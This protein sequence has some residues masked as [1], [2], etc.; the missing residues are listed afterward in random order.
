MRREWNPAL[1]HFVIFP[2]G[3]GSKTVI[4]LKTMLKD[5]LEVSVIIPA[6]NEAE[7]IATVITQIKAALDE[8]DRAYEILVIDDGCTDETAARA[9]AAGAHV[10][11][12][13]YNI[14]NGAAIKTGIRNARGEIIVMLDADGQ[15]PPEDISRL[16]EKM[17][18]YDMIVGARTSASDTDI[19]RNVANQIYNWLASYI[20]GQKIEDLT[21]GF[22]AIKTNVARGF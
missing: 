1:L 4:N 22:R 20:S 11:Q 7:V 8:S 18:R 14:G 21:S 16:L 13:A 9:K 3:I 15:H 10:L 12:H 17:G 6:Y 5:N 2:V 19:H